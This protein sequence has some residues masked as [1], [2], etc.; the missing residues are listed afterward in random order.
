MNF[1]DQEFSRYISKDGR[2]DPFFKERVEDALIVL[3]MYLNALPVQKSC[4]SCQHARIDDDAKIFCTY[5]DAVPPMHVQQRGCEEW[6][7]RDE[8]P[9]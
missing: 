9:F 8:V 7:F 4:A 3:K 5:A 2:I 6:I 1:H